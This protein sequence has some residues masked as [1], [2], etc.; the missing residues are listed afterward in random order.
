MCSGRETPRGSLPT[1][2]PPSPSLVLP[3]LGPWSGPL[4]SSCPCVVQRSCL[5]GVGQDPSAA[6]RN[7]LPDS[8]CLWPCGPD[9]AQRHQSV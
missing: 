5:I 4:L 2:H 6:P 7:Q 8:P 9:G 1:R 3:L